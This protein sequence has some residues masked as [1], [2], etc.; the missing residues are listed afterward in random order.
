MSDIYELKVTDLERSFGELPLM[1]FGSR[2]SLPSDEKME[3]IEL[4]AGDNEFKEDHFLTSANL[5]RW[6][7]DY[8]EIQVQRVRRHR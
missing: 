8:D 3:A 2:R 6:I 5:C 4:T 7:I 1:R